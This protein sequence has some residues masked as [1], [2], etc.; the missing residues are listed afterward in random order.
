MRLNK[1]FKFLGFKETVFVR[2]LNLFDRK[3]IY[4]VYAQS[5]KPDLPLGLE[6]N[7]RNLN[8]YDDPSNYGPPR[9]VRLGA[10]IDF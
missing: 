5:G 10:S 7:D 9:E 3:N 1:T 8:I 2:V 6:R 4:Y